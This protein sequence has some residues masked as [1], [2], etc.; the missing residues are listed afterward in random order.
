MRQNTILLGLIAFVILVSGCVQP[1]PTPVA[2]TQEAR[3]CPDGS[4]VGRVPPRCEFA[5]CP[6]ASPATAHVHARDLFPYG[7]YLGGG[8][9]HDLQQT[10]R[11]GG[12]GSVE[13]Y[14]ENMTSSME[15]G[16]F[17]TVWPNN[18]LGDAGEYEELLRVWGQ[19]ARRHGLRLIPQGG[20][21]PGGSEEIYR[22]VKDWPA[23][24]FDRPRGHR[25][26]SEIE[27]PLTAA[28][29]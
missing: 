27:P 23:G 8:T 11:E 17:N 29:Q 24:G 4:A 25:R 10:A 20:P 2:C 16:G 1:T 6:A 3:I 26:P 7:V 18:L 15:R 13:N 12:F 28:R 19:A 9:L 5:P 21:F 14:L 22:S